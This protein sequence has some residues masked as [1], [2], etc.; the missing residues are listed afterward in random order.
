LINA[1]I[2]STR[3]IN[4]S[5]HTTPALSIVEPSIIQPEPINPDGSR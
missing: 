2:A 1:A 4:A 3:T 5:R